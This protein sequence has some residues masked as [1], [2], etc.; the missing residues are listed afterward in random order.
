MAQLNKPAAP[1]NVIKRIP[2]F[3]SVRIELAASGK[4]SGTVTADNNRRI[5]IERIV[6]ETRA[7]SGLAVVDGC[8]LADLKDTVNGSYTKGQIPVATLGGNG[9]R[10]MPNYLP[11]ELKIEPSTDLIVE[12]ANQVATA[13]TVDVCFVGY[14]EII[15]K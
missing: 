2:F 14:E 5:V 12:L 6:Q 4:G 9:P 7:T 11:A 13:Y 1:S 3:K 8:I 15:R 10:G